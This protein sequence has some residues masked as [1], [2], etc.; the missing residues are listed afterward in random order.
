M[1][2]TLKR[3][4]VFVAIGAALFVLFDRFGPYQSGGGS[5]PKPIEVVS[6]AST[7]LR[8]TLNGHYYASGSINGHEVVFL[9]DTGATT[10]SVDQDTAQRLGLGACRETIYGTAAGTVRGCEARARELRVAGLSL[11]EV[12]VAVM[13]AQREPLVLLGMNVLRHF[14]V[15]TEAGTMRLTPSAK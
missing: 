10:V 11:R 14:R 15:E 9:V 7:E 6:G 2:S 4:T 1:A 8:R 5:R 3:A 13:P 12:R